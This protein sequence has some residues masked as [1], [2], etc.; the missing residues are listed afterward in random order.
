MNLSNKIYVNKHLKA[1]FAL[2]LLINLDI[3]Q[4]Y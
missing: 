1:S 2:H 4:I 3:K